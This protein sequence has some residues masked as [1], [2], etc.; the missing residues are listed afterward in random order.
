M[1]ISLKL[2]ITGLSKAMLLLVVYYVCDCFYVFLLL[3]LAHL[4]RRPIEMSLYE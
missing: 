4:S 3:R 2:F 1:G